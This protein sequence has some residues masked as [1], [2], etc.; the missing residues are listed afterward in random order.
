MQRCP[1]VQRQ[2]PVDDRG[3]RRQDSDRGDNVVRL[4]NTRSPLGF[5]NVGDSALHSGCGIWTVLEL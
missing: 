5:F 3:K 1:H 4:E 2:K